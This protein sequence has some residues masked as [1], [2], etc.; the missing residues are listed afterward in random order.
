MPGPWPLIT[1]LSVRSI[2]RD[3]KAE[4][5]VA[6]LLPEEGYPPIAENL[7]GMAEAAIC[8]LL[9]VGSAA[10]LAADVPH[11]DGALLPDR[12]VLLA[13]MSSAVAGGLEECEVT[14]RAEV[15]IEWTG[16]GSVEVAAFVAT[17]EEA[18]AACPAGGGCDER[19]FK[20]HALCGEAIKVWSPDHRVSSAP[21]GMIALVVSEEEKNVG[22]AQAG[23][24]EKEAKEGNAENCHVM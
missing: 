3:L 5:L 1:I 8:L 24:R 20:A 13:E 10:Q 9:E 12:D 18:G 19:I 6:P 4:W 14:C 2:K 15:G 16:G 21:K 11:G 22:L 23:S 17:G 7:G